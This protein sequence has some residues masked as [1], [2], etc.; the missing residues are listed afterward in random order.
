MCEGLCLEACSA[1]PPHFIQSQGQMKGATFLPACSP[2]TPLLS[3]AGATLMVVSMRVSGQNSLVEAWLGNCIYM[4][5]W[6]S[7]WFRGWEPIT[8]IATALREVDDVEG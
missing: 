2:H 6:F 3:G 5:W 7:W 1:P 4:M 8:F